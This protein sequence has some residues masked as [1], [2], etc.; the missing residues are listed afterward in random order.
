ML[1]ISKYVH[2]PKII[3][4]FV[5]ANEDAITFEKF[6][7]IPLGVLSL[8]DIFVQRAQINALF[9]QLRDM[10]KSKVLYMNF[11]IHPD[12]GSETEYRQGVYNLFK[13]KSF[14]TRGKKQSFLNEMRES[15]QHKFIISPKGDMY[16]CYRHWEALL[17]GSIPIV[18]STALDAIFEDLPVIIVDDYAEVNEEFLYTQ[19]QELQSKPYNLRKLY[20][21]Y[22]VDRINTA[23]SDFFNKK[24]ISFSCLENLES[25]DHINK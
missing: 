23:R 14:C 12:R 7:L 5:Q 2:D 18:Q 9:K 25:S 4:W 6:N 22:W 11:T 3:A 13:D 19:Y 16:D 10:P 21:Q 15:A 20:M 1:H 17:V 24:G 8:G